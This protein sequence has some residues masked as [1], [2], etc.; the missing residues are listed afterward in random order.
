MVESKVQLMLMQLGADCSTA[1]SAL[2]NSTAA[3]DAFAY[4]L[5]WATALRGINAREGCI[6]Q[7]WLPASQAQPSQPA[8]PSLF[9]IFTLQPGSQVMIVPDR[10]ITS[11]SVNTAGIMLIVQQNPLMD[12]LRWLNI[13]MHYDHAAHSPITNA[14]V[15]P[16]TAAIRRNFWRDLHCSLR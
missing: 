16:L 12:P 15:R 5:L 3:R 9:P 2:A 7:I 10:L 13:L 4:S 1:P 8:M 6:S 14:I 11:I